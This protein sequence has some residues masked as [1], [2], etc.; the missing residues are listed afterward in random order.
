MVKHL[1]IDADMAASFQCGLVVSVAQLGWCWQ[2]VTNYSQPLR[3]NLYMVLIDLNG[4]QFDWKRGW[5]NMWQPFPLDFG[6]WDGWYEMTPYYWIQLILGKSC[7]YICIIC[8][9]VVAY[10]YEHAHVLCTLGCMLEYVCDY[11]QVCMS[12]WYVYSCVLQW[13]RP[14]WWDPD[15]CRRSISVRI[16]KTRQRFGSKKCIISGECSLF[17]YWVFW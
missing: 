1:A 4:L 9:H 7:M 2:P 14:I 10:V 16:V 13:F 17:S 8:V 3:R 6:F 12:M 11:V 5:W 15:R